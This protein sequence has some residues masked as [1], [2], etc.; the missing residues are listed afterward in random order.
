RQAFVSEEVDA[1]VID[2]YYSQPLPT[3]QSPLIGKTF[4]ELAKGAGQYAIFYQVFPHPDIGDLVVF[5]LLL[6]G[7]RIVLGTSDGI[8][9]AL[10][11]GLH[12][13]LLKW[14]GVRAKTMPPRKKKDDQAG[15]N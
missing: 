10:S 1:L 12:H 13:K 14:M 7:V 6:G 9:T 15:L 5:F 2:I 11:Q 3:M 8:A 4:E